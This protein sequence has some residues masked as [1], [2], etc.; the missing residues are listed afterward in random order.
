MCVRFDGLDFDL[1]DAA[2][3]LKVVSPT[4]MGIVMKSHPNFLC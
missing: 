3:D 1:V 4:M 2:T